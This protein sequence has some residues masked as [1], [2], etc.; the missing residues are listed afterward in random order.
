MTGIIDPARL[1]NGRAAEF[2]EQ[3][4]GPEDLLTIGMST[5]TWF[6][7][8]V[9]TR[10]E[11]GNIEVLLQRLKAGI[12]DAAAEV[13]FVDD[14]DD[15]TPEVIRSLGREAGL[16]VR[17]LHRPAGKR[18]GGLSSAVTEGLRVARG[19]WAVV[20]DGD[21]QHPPELAAKLVAIGQSRDLD[22]VAG[23]RYQ[24]SGD[25]GGLS[26]GFRRGVS[27]F[28]TDRDQGAVPAPAQPAV[29]S[30]VRLLR[31]PA[32][33]RQSGSAEPDRF[34]DPARDRGSPAAAADRRGAVRLRRP[35]GRREQG[36][37][38]GRAC[39]SSSTCCGCG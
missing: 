20:M 25:A 18:H 23:T 37:A 36:R 35:V 12:G 17:L 28:T 26:G 29:G 16:P 22:L 1:D 33:R 2:S 11:A 10:N 31:D 32:G 19:S 5:S 38:R 7:V 21:L 24:G 13:L 34:Q 15:A 3:V 27:S 39:G 8:I 9:P 14:S 4:D 30:D 6:T